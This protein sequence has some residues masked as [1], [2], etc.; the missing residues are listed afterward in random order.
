MRG[1]LELAEKTGDHEGNLLTD[2]NS[3]VSDPFDCPG[4]E[5]HGHRPLATV[6][7]ISDLEGNGETLPVQ[8][9]DQVV[10][11]DQVLGRS[12]IPVCESLPGLDYLETGLGAHF[13]DPADHVL[14]GRGFVTDDRDQ[15]ADVHA[16]VPHP[17]GVLDDVEQS[18]DESQ[19]RCHRGLGRQE[20]DETLVDLEIAAIDAVIVVGDDFRK[21]DVLVLDCLEGPVERAHDEIESTKGLGFQV[22]KLFLVLDS[23]LVSH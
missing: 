2:V 18:G 5:K 14:V 4:R 22:V 17:L 12:F 16:L 23:D 20:G 1:I 11:P 10:L 13:E 8:L 15:F 21:L 6:M 7:F 19:I 3:V 9:V